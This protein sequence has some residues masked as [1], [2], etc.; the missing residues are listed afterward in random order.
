MHNDNAFTNKR[1]STYSSFCISIVKPTDFILREGDEI[2]SEND[3]VLT[4]F[5]IY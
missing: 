1:Y 4:F 3:D 5:R 2:D